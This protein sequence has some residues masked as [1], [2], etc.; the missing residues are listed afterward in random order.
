MI[1][2]KACYALRCHSA[3]ERWAN[4]TLAR[5]DDSCG[6]RDLEAAVTRARGVARFPDQ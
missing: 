3:R 6:G 4:L 2:G 1:R 5:P